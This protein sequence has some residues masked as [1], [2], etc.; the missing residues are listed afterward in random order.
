M[1][2]LPTDVTGTPRH[3]FLS[4]VR[5]GAA[6]QI[7]GSLGADGR[8]TIEVHL[9]ISATLD[10]PPSPRGPV[11][12]PA[13]SMHDTSVTISL[14][15]PGDVVGFDARAIC[16]VWPKP[17]AMDAENNL[18]PLVEF[19]EADLPWRYTPAATSDQLLPWIAL[20]VL[21]DGEFT[22]EPAGSNHP[23]PVLVPRAGVPF[24]RVD[25][26]WAWAHAHVLPSEIFTGSSIPDP[27][28]YAKTQISQYP[29]RV[30]ARLVA[31]RRLHS[32]TAYTA[33]L[34]PTFER[35]RL[36]GLGLPLGSAGALDPAWRPDDQ[37]LL[38]VPSGASPHRLPI[39]YQWRFGT[40]A[41][42]DFEF[43][44]SRITARPAPPELGRRAMDL[45]Q[46]VSGEQVTADDVGQLEA[47]LRPWIP[48]AEEPW[49]P[50]WSRLGRSGFYGWFRILTAPSLSTPALAPPLY[51]EW[52]AASHMLA[53]SQG[54]GWFN[55]LNA[56]P[57]TRVA[58][59]MGTLVV[60][61]LQEPLM[62]SAWQQ[63]AGIRR[64]NEELRF[65]QLARQA[66]IT[67]HRRDL[68]TAFGDTFFR[69]TAPVLANVLE[70][71]VTVRERFARS[72]IP[73]GVLQG[74]WRRLSRARS[75]MRKRR[76]R[77]SPSWIASTA[78]RSRR[79]G[80]RRTLPV[81]R[82]RA[83]CSTRWRRATP[84]SPRRLQSSVAPWP[85]CRGRGP[86]WG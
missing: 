3:L 30:V 61:T 25:Q 51:G 26:L 58:A 36:A 84:R 8:A 33:F 15:G 22:L 42:G 44:A 66:S 2:D 29:E 50:A 45:R 79:P 23:L 41:E 53:P 34:V 57:R 21:A 52:Q 20:I 10:A 13:P 27:R 65:N 74:T 32:R 19:S 59:G 38:Q 37:G 31:A 11:P 4:A 12:A 83:R 60:Q 75:P 64:I 63:L 17:D 6:T 18:F 55:E 39:Y 73:T 67:T 56:D 43:L 62:A 28:G 81:W 82:P 35:G 49:S 14:L 24:P 70:G 16:R 54:T 78:E 46:P 76:R 68:S 77:R 7:Q 1:P 71:E 86:S 47:A 5:R 69:L 9:N 80:R 48:A 85:P 72:P 40:G